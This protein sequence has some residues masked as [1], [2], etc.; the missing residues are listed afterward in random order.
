MTAVMEVIRLLLRSSRSMP[1]MPW[2][3]LSWM[4]SMSLSFMKMFLSCRHCLKV[5]GEMCFN[6][7]KEMSKVLK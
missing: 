3:V 2:K 5:V 1:S 7:L 6:L 4:F